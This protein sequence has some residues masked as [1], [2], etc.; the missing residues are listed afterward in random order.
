MEPG[1][2][3]QDQLDT[4]R[5]E[6]YVP[7]AMLRLLARERERRVRAIDGTCV[8]VDVSG[9]T[10]L[11]ERLARRGGREGAEQLADAIGSCF[12]RLLAVAYANGGGLL[13][14]GGDALLLLFDGDRHAER[15]CWSAAAMCSELRENGSIDTGTTTVDLRVSVGVHSAEYLLFAVGDSHRE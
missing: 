4:G 6:P 14:F 11:A 13:K 7:R 12:E 8:F 15:A 2:V 10:K 9:F 3:L 1:V 5:A